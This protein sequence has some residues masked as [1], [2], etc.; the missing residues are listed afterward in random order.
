MI[1]LLILV[2]LVVGYLLGSVPFGLIFVKL[3]SGKDVRLFG[4]GRIGG[5]NAMRTGGLFAGALTALF[6]TLK[7]LAAVMIA[8]AILPELDWVHV[9]AGLL[10]ILGHNYSIFLL[11]RNDKGKL[12]LRGGAGGATCLGGAVGLWFPALWWILIPGVIVYIFIG[13][14]SVTTISVAVLS[15]IILGYRA[16]QGLGPW[17]DAL[18]GV[19]AL[20]LILWALLPNLERLRLGTERAVGLRARAHKRRHHHAAHNQP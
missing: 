18:Y 4:S 2:S 7:G 9:A 16:Y 3:I 13:Y 11:T 14:A 8:E 20:L 17:V 5:T 15:I 1:I 6:D 10:A 12:A 19:G